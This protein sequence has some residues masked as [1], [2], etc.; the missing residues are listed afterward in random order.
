MSDTGDRDLATLN[1]LAPALWQGLPNA[2]SLRSALLRGALRRLRGCGMLAQCAFKL[3]IRVE[4]SIERSRIARHELLARDGVLLG[5]WSRLGSSRIGALP[6]NVVIG[7]YSSIGSNVV[8]ANENHPLDRLS[9]SGLFYDP[10]LGCVSQ[11]MLPQR[12]FLMIGH[13]V[14]I[15]SNASILPGCRR[16]GHGAVI[17]AGAVVTHDV[18]P[19]A[20]VGGN[21]AR[22]IRRR[23]EGEIAAAWIASR[24][25]NHAP[26][27]LVQ[28]GVTNLPSAPFFSDSECAFESLF[29]AR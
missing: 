9:T 12:P 4:G 25:W 28:H 8:I 5:A 17:G 1:E 2:M 24:W 23:L 27:T 18:E 10:L 26:T 21:P 19:L 11:R 7:R 22:V 14:W 13:D 29:L 16:I 6:P 15:G 20:I 3:A